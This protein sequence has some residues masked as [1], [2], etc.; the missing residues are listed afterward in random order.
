MSSSAADF[1]PGAPEPEWD[2]RVLVVDDD[3]VAR[4]AATGLLENLGLTVDCAED[5]R[6]AVEMAAQRP[7][8]AIFMDCEMPD[9]DGYTAARQ[10]RTRDGRN[11]HT[12]VIAVTAKQR[13]VSLASGMVH[14]LTKPLAAD[15]L[16][17]D[18]RRLGVLSGVSPSPGVISQ[19]LTLDVPLLSPS[20]FPVAGGAQGV[21]VTKRARIFL[22]EVT[23]HLPELWRAA[24]AGTGAS[25]VALAA[26]LQERATQVGTERLARLCA[27][28]AQAAGPRPTSRI[29]DLEPAFRV[30]IRDTA[31][32]LADYEAGLSDVHG[33]PPGNGSPVVEPLAIVTASGLPEPG[34]PDPDRPESDRRAPYEPLRVALADD[35]PIA[36]MVVGAMLADV[37]W[38]DLVGCAA[39]VREIVGLADLTRPHIVVVDWMMPDGGGPEA[40]RRILARH[41]DTLIVGLTS[42]DNA[43]ALTEMSAAGAIC[44]VAKGGSAEQL[45]RTIRRAL[46]AVSAARRQ[47]GAPATAPAPAPAPAAGL[48]TPGAI[49]GEGSLDP[50][51]IDRLQAEFGSTILPDLVDLFGAQTPERLGE[52]R[53]ANATGDRSAIATVSHQLKGGCL[54][55]AAVRMAELCSQLEQVAAH[56]TRDGVA[57][58]ID[59]IERD[60]NHVHPALV[61]IASVPAA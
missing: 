28:L 21:R 42:S 48:E 32:A 61:A 45:T 38:L 55:L 46:N 26:A 54:T 53:R 10:I 56:A 50:A 22:R 27:L 14:H 60:F 51:G 47:A 17:A 29:E 11:A 31:Q 2:P 4:L 49:E 5:G 36:R 24:N 41:P 19:P 8:V 40:S 35:D 25:L 9:V 18:C 3:D 43:K 39:G 7:Y 58:L 16:E 12:P 20:V 37:D 52:L 13:S 6:Q 34:L 15:V 59:R 30:V 44:L 1:V 33:R 57:D 23:N